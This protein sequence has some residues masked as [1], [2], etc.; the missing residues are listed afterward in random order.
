MSRSPSWA[1]RIK[2][3]DNRMRISSRSL[4]ASAG[5]VLTNCHDLANA[6]VK[7]QF[8]QFFADQWISGRRASYNRWRT[9]SSIALTPSCAEPRHS[10]A[11]DALLP[12]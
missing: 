6:A 8:H 9:L 2:R 11:I 4:C 3:L 7:G 10:E 1:K 5:S 12:G